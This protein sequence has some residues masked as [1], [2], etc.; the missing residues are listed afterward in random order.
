MSSINQLPQINMED[1]HAD[2]VVHVVHE[3]RDHSMRFGEYQA[4]IDGKISDADAAVQGAVARANELIQQ[5]DATAI[6]N[7]INDK[8]AELDA[9][10]PEKRIVQTLRIEGSSDYLYPVWFIWSDNT[11]GTGKVTISRPFF[12][13]R[14]VLHPTHSA[15]L[16]LELEGNG[17]QW[18][19][20]ANFMEIKR[21]A[22][23]YHSSCSHV[24]FQG[25]T[26][27]RQEGATNLEYPENEFG[28]ICPVY[29][30][31]YL[32]GGGLDY[33]ISSNFEISFDHSLESTRVWRSDSHG[34]W[35]VE[36][37]HMDNRI[38]PTTTVNAYVDPI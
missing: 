20:D 12:W 36:P 7:Q 8:I 10:Q 15:A 29:S 30:T 21:F 22:E 17:W 11:F 5:S 38:A 27:Y 25:Y 6:S 28:P 19:G 14:D 9:A 23:K 18:A 37:I 3:G 33:Q 35:Y 24:S 16:L 1:M 4:L 13:N 32:R 2:S 34:S 26:R 31:V